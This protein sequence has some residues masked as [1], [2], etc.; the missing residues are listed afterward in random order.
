MLKNCI[1][2]IFRKFTQSKS[3]R[4]YQST[5]SLYLAATI[6]SL[7][8]S[9]VFFVA[10]F[11]ILAFWIALPCLL[12]ISTAIMFSRNMLKTSL[13]T[14]F[15]SISIICIASVR[16]LGL[17]C[18]AQF[19]LLCA[20]VL[21][22]TNELN[23]K[24]T[25]YIYGVLCLAEYIILKV[26][27]GQINPIYTMPAATL[28]IIEQI[29]ILM[30]FGTVVYTMNSY[31]FA[32]RRYEIKL[33]DINSEVTYLANYDQLTGIE[34]R[35]YLHQKLDLLFKGSL[36]SNE[37]FVVG[38]VDVDDFKRINDQYGHFCGDEVLQHTSKV[39]K[40]SLRK[41]D[42]VGR[43]GGEEFLVV[44]P[45]TDMADG[46]EILERVRV[47]LE[48]SILNHDNSQIKT[49]ITIGAAEFKKTISLDD[50]IQQADQ[51]LYWGKQNGKNRVVHTITSSNK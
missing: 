8:Y 43:W 33:K 45:N 9:L 42:F 26:S 38:M 35:H 51:R 31:I 17:E 23:G 16:I 21:Y 11:D 25:N 2:E 36:K 19:Y 40:E 7:I 28:T 48:N 13:F 15:L 29:N 37:G 5:V 34:N 20:M 49:T 4:N 46:L 27:F 32:V 30:A 50:L 10:G 41:T 14:G 39:L 24:L 12:F 22:L 44:L 1:T 6:G 18:G 47:S 3:D